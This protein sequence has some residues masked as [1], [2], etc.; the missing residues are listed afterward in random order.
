M[1]PAIKDTHISNPVVVN[2]GVSKYGV[3]NEMTK[4]YEH[5]KLPQLDECA[6]DIRIMNN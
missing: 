3:F 6:K 2:I 5:D 4:Q 1:F